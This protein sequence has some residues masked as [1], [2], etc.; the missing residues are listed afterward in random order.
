[1]QPAKMDTSPSW[2]FDI[3]LQ[4]RGYQFEREKSVMYIYIEYKNKDKCN[5][6]ISDISLVCTRHI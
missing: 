4:R 6:Y 3:K 2:L 1:M 5:L